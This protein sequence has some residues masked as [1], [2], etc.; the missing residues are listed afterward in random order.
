MFDYVTLKVIWWA[1]MTT[2]LIGFAVTGGLDLGVNFL[3]PI[4]GRT[5]EDRRLILNSSGP[6]WEGNQV[7]LITFGAGLF[8]IWP[9]AYAT[10]FSSMY[11]AIMLALLVLILRPP[12][13]D[14]RSKLTSIA[15]RS[16]WDYCLFASSLILGLVF[17]IAV[18][19]LF[20]GLDF[21]FTPE[22]NSIYKGSF[23]SLFEFFPILI[24]L[25]SICMFTVQ[26]G[27]FLQYKLSG[28]LISRAQK[29][30]KISGAI[31]ILGFIYAGV[32]ASRSTG[33]IILNMPDP[34]TAFDATKKIVATAP[35]AWLG[36]YMAYPWLWALPVTTIIA[37]KLALVFSSYNKPIRGLLLSSLAII[38]TILTAGVALFP[39]IIPSSFD[40]NHSLTIWDASSS[41]LTLEW[42][43]WVVVLLLPIV[44]WYTT[45]VYRV[46]RG[47]T[48]LHANS[49]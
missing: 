24:G 45:W 15:W 36:N 48:T 25:L 28:E 12:G 16:T 9:A 34:N 31:F 29:V 47:K 32:L 3:L 40:P 21:Y 22:L 13:V 1:L 19:N 11:Y 4:I 41:K 2:V 49:Y 10:A 27:L 35:T 30:V 42:T 20:I 8:A 37:M 7:W 38:T 46:M 26:G 17:G 23:F 6:T 33:Y 44:L 14:Y 39:F 18:G 5:D 43:F